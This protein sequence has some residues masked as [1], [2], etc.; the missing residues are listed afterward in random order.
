M[1]CRFWLVA[2]IRDFDFVVVAEA[3]SATSV[4]SSL[5]LLLWP[6]HMQL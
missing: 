5:V 1:I 3:A 4:L 2:Y 6:L